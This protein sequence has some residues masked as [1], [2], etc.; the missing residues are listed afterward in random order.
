MRRPTAP[1]Q[2]SETE[3]EARIAEGRKTTSEGETASLSQ[4]KKNI[5]EDIKILDKIQGGLIKKNKDILVAKES[6]KKEKEDAR[7]DFVEYK[8]EIEEEKKILH[9]GVDIIKS[10]IQKLNIEMDD[11]IS[12]T[13][14]LSKNKTSLRDEI[15]VLDIDI[16][17]CEI[18]I[19][20]QKETLANLPNPKD[21]EAEIANKK[22]EL[23]LIKNQVSK[24]EVILSVFKDKI[25]GAE[26]KLTSLETLVSLTENELVSLGK[27]KEEILESIRIENQKLEERQNSTNERASVAA[28]AE[29]R[30]EEKTQLLL[31]LIE[32]AKSEKLIQDFQ[33]T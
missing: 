30:I 24:A 9:V 10:Q 16:S 23:E 3:E 17:N 2:V 32:K 25:S 29:R 21:I 28:L 5:E 8:K 12:S 6:Y 7:L 31:R 26:K 33:I 27:K 20:A 22:D 1:Q 4:A 13:N 19:K 14:E 15:N 18:K 11:I